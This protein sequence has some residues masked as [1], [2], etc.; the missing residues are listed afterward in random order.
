MP[1]P[2]VTNCYADSG[3]IIGEEIGTG[4]RSTSVVHLED[5]CVVLRYDNGKTYTVD[6]SVYDVRGREVRLLR[7]YRIDDSSPWRKFIPP[8]PRSFD[9]LISG[10]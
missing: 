5:V 10:R 4:A 8:P 9:L 1:T 2:T 7:A 3:R 6:V